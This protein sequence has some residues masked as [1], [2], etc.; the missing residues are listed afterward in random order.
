VGSL[1]VT[2]SA[3]TAKVAQETIAKNK[4]LFNHDDVVYIVTVTP[5]DIE[6]CRDYSTQILSL[7]SQT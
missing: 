2:G 7:K 3:A 6:I 4:I 5:F 1:T